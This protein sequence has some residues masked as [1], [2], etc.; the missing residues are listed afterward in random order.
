[1]E[2]SLCI[3]ARASGR[4]ASHA[5][6]RD[7][8]YDRRD[9]LTKARDRARERSRERARERSRGR[10]RDRERSRDRGRRRPAMR[11][12]TNDARGRDGDGDDV[13][14]TNDARGRD[15]DG[16]DVAAALAARCRAALGEPREKLGLLRDVVELVGCLKAKALLERT[17]FRERGAGT[18]T[19]DGSRRRSPGGAF[20]ALVKDAVAPADYR[21]LYASEARRRR[22]DA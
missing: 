12:A 17:L 21:A 4:D 14:A 10:E 22:R 7:L 16:D 8:Y 18:A 11:D 3:D 1:M 13:A 15:G 19:A 20:M 5:G 9:E 2:H 6:A